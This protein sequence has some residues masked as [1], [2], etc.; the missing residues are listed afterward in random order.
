MQRSIEELIGRL[1][2]QICS[3]GILQSRIIPG[4]SQAHPGTVRVRYCHL[5]KP[6]PFAGPSVRLRIKPAKSSFA[7]SHSEDPQGPGC[8]HVLSMWAVRA[9]SHPVSRPMR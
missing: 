9:G 8:T 1:K 6:T 3:S 5:G 7:M 4:E 2:P